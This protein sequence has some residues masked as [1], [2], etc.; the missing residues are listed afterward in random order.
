VEYYRPWVFLITDGAPTDHWQDAARM[1]KEGEENRQFQF[2]AVGVQ[3]ANFEVLKK[4]SVRD[5]LQLQGLRFKDLFAWLSNSLSAVS[6]SQVGE[7][8]NLVNPAVPGGWAT[9]G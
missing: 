9:V 4:I 1:V 6:H 8:V 5:P 7:Q 2:F 3:G